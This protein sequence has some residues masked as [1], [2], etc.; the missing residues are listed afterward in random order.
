MQL[1]PWT[2]AA[3][4]I[5]RRLSQPEPDIAAELQHL[6]T[7]VSGNRDE[8]GRLLGHTIWGAADLQI[9]L[10]WDWTE[11]LAGVYAMSDPLHV[12]SNIG[13]VDTSGVVVPENLTAVYLNRITHALPWQAEISRA[14]TAI[15][16]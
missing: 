11:T 4:P 10:A 3:W 2:I 6:G 13:F 9:G 15:S 12:L 8:F 14:T 1:Q 16:I 7:V 5:V